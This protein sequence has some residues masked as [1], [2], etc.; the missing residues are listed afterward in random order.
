MNRPPLAMLCALLCSML[1]TA[2]ALAVEATVTLPLS[3]VEQLSQVPATTPPQ[4]TVGSARWTGRIDSGGAIALDATLTVQ[5]SGDGTKQVPLLDAEAVLT[6]VLVD[7]RAV[8]ISLA[9]G[10]YVWLTDGT[11]PATVRLKGW[12]PPR[13]QG[14]SLEYDVG[15]PTTA[16]TSLSLQLPAADLRPEVRAA[17]R[18]RVVTRDG[19]PWL[20]ADLSPTDRLHIV[21]LRDLQTDADRPAEL[22]AQTNH[23]VS[24]D[25][26]RIEVFSVVRYSILYAASRTFEVFV[27]EGLTVSD[28]DGQGAFDYELVDVPGGQ[29]LRGQTRHPIRNRYELSLRLQRPLPEGELSV[30]LPEARQVVRS[31]GWVGLE[32][33]GR[34]RVTDRHGD[35]LVPLPV[36]Q[37]PAEVREASVSPLLDAWRLGERG[38]VNLSAARLPEV[39]VSSERIDA[40]A[41][42]TV[43]A[44]NGRQVTELTLQL[45]NRSRHGLGVQLPPGATITRATRD[46]EP[47]TPAQR[48]DRVVLP[49]RRTADGRPQTLQLVVAHDRDAPG[50]RGR[51]DLALPRLDLPVAA[52][53]WTVHLPTS[54]R[55]SE[56][57]ADVHSQ[58]RV[59]S[60]SWLA[61][62]GALAAAGATPALPTPASEATEVRHYQRYWLDADTPVQLGVRYTAPWLHA[63][64]RLL[65]A[66][67]FLSIAAVGL[68]LG[69]KRA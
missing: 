39:E 36:H 1:S 45:A 46:G 30:A 58:T 21:G 44:A 34:V 7:G 50:T 56:L 23:L 10:R 4:A 33:P 16:A 2:S 43:L 25:D 67:L 54:H 59:G 27:P 15:I 14:A 12:V 8:P 48:D 53:D 26:R 47:V 13:H 32:V 42:R 68:R 19:A 51:F 17:V 29:L 37:L 57:D 31:H 61:D 55:W 28:A 49:L 6:E 11:G 60:G 20:L 52:L 40:V 65:G 69:A 62:R 63:L 41:A 5:R 35:G 22:F 18:S 38:T 66:G 24:V 9:G 3:E 64:L